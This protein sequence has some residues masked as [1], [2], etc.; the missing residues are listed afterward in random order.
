MSIVACMGGWCEKRL[1][2]AHYWSRSVAVSERLCER[3]NDRPE[4]MVRRRFDAWLA[5]ATAEQQAA[6]EARQHKAETVPDEQL[7]PPLRGGNLEVF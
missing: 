4:P 6:W 1:E 3:G 2:C 7:P 5:G